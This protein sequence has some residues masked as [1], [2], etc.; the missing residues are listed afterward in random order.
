MRVGVKC[1]CCTSCCQQG[2]CSGT[3]C[4]Y[5]KI[6]PVLLVPDNV[7]GEAPCGHMTRES[8]DALCPSVR[9]SEPVERD[10]MLELVC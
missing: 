9:P 7:E 1:L 2:R 6:F 5:W 4:F 3:T 8:F 10:W